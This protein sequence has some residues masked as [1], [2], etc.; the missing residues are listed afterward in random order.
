MR[1]GVGSSARATPG[2]PGRGGVWP[3]AGPSGF[4]P[5]DGGSEEL[6][7]VFAGRSSF[8]RRASSSA[9]RA[10][11]A[12]SCPTRGNSDRISASFSA[13][14]SLLRSMGGVTPKLNRVAR[15]GVNHHLVHCPP[16]RR[17]S[18][19]TQVSNY[20][21]DAHKRK[22][23]IINHR[24]ASSFHDQVNSCCYEQARYYTLYIHM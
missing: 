8:L 3:P 2:R 13:T 24:I 12:S 23:F 22:N 10:S 7:G 18:G 14:V 4:W 5:R 20:Y 6:A 21:S 15:D 1:S 9:I 17:R 16:R 11:A 19:A